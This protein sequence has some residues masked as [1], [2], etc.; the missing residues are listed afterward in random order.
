MRGKYPS[1]QWE[2][3][4]QV[5]WGYHLFYTCTTVLQY[6]IL[7]MYIHN[8]SLRLKILR[9]IVYV[10]PVLFGLKI[11]FSHFSVAERQSLFSFFSRAFEFLLL[12][13]CFYISDNEHHVWIH[14]ICSFFSF[15][16]RNTALQTAI[17]DLYMYPHNYD[18][19]DKGV[20]SLL[21]SLPPFAFL[22][23]FVWMY[24]VQHGARY[25]FRGR[26]IFLDADSM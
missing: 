24:V 4:T 21:I 15:F 3:L 7:P 12:L 16:I 23:S 8:Y 2:E 11:S 6:I 10:F 25:A 9:Q 22:Y 13:F 14:C 5:Y 20:V 19:S 18:A 1:I 17:W 26:S